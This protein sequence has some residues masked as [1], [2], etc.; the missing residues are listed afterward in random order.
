M[1]AYIMSLSLLACL[2]AVSSVAA[3]T[4]LE[5]AECFK[6]VASP[7]P[8]PASATDEAIATATILDCTDAGLTGP[9]PDALG[10]LAHL[11]VVELSTNALTGPLPPSLGLLTDLVTL[12]V[13]NNRLT[14]AAF[15]MAAILGK[16]TLLA[17]LDVGGNLFTGSIPDA[18]GDLSRLTTLSFYSNQLTGTIPGHAFARLTA[19]ADVFGNGNKFAGPIP[20]ALP[21]SATHVQFANNHLTGTVPPTLGSLSKLRTLWLNENELTGCVPRNIALC[22]PSLRDEKA[23]AI[24]S[25]DT[26][27]KVTG[28]CTVDFVQFLREHG[29]HEYHDTLKAEGVNEIDDLLD[30]SD[31]DVFALRGMKRVHARRLLNAIEAHREEEK[32]EL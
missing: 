2:L 29:L 11:T 15:P 8:L 6:R 30:L 32:S 9:I 10:D 7:E 22:A 14:G 20:A 5:D 16:L 13:D 25:G 28:R 31:D 3:A 18:I 19:L 12:N 1:A 27:T 17:D 24:T 4:K 23:C 21:H 26:N